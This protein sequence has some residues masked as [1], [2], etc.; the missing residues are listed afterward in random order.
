[1]DL[2][3]WVVAGVILAILGLVAFYFYRSTR[4]WGIPPADLD[5]TEGRKLLWIRWSRGER[6]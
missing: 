4:R 2:L 5:T 6:G 3:W 1:M